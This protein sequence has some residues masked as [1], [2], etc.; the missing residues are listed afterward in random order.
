MSIVKKNGTGGHSSFE[1]RRLCLAESQSALWRGCSPAESTQ[2]FCRSDVACAGEC[3]AVRLPLY[4]VELNAGAGGDID[5]ED[6][7]RRVG[8]NPMLPTNVHRPSFLD[9]SFGHVITSSERGLS[10]SAFLA[11]GD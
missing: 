6:V 7:A 5:D 3:Q 4:T 9:N 1:C 8:L 2:N 10:D 11:T